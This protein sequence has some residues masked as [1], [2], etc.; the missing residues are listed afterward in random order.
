MGEFLVYML[1][2]AACLAVF[3]LFYKCLLCRESFHRF[4]RL[5]LLCMGPLACVLPCVRITRE[6]TAPLVPEILPV[7]GWLATVQSGEILQ[8]AGDVHVFT[9]PD[10]VVLV[11]MA[12]VMVS[13][14]WEMGAVM[15]ICRL[16]R[17][18]KKRRVGGICL[19][20][21]QK[22]MAPFS[23]MKYVVISENDLKEYG[24][25]IL[26]HE[27]A[28]IRLHHS[29]DLLLAELL[30]CVQWFNPAAWCLKHELQT[31]HEYEADE[32]VVVRGGVDAKEY[33]L[34]LI[35]KAVG[36]RLYSLA[37]SFNHSSLKKR[38]TMMRRKSNPWARMK[39]LYVLPLAAMSVVAFA[40]PEVS[41]SLAGISDVKI[42]D[43]SA[44][45]KADGVENVENGQEIHRKDS[46]VGRKVVVRSKKRDMSNAE[47]VVVGYTSGSGEKPEN[48]FDA[49]DMMPEYPGG[50]KECFRFL[51]K[52][53]RY[54]VKAIEN[55]TEGKVVVRFVVEK[56]GSLSGVHVLN[57]ADSYLDAEA[58]RVVRSMPK[59]NPGQLDGKPVRTRF[60]LPVVFKLQEQER[61]TKTDVGQTAGTDAGRVNP[62]MSPLVFVDGTEYT[63]DLSKIDPDRIESISVL[64]D[65]RATAAYGIKGKNGVILVKTKTSG[66][67]NAPV[68]KIEYNEQD[69]NAVV[70]ITTAE[71]E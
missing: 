29:C 23:W 24:K 2:S 40:R 13:L 59:W 68:S 53:L 31:V 30:V 37:N 60:V 32:A 34:I 46:L 11:Y 27:Q 71:K 8:E 65:G 54:P 67:L 15:H 50:M 64:K 70:R 41:G 3:F 47:V 18:G 42:T 14:L 51:A 5:L 45:V 1:K 61:K 58:L 22:E 38:I 62:E 26:L 43:L 48:I 21:H 25:V 57:G 20:V 10:M 63:G 19:V 55:R 69:K 17:G 33:Q 66:K 9:W 35:K 4:N 6:G 52:N 28:H 44:I 36:A 56:D 39:G 49:V 12:G 7:D 16:L